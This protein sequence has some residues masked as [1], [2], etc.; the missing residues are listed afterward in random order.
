MEQEKTNILYG[1]APYLI[2]SL[3]KLAQCKYYIIVYNKLWNKV[4]QKTQIDVNIRFQNKGDSVVSTKFF[5]SFLGCAISHN[6][7]EAFK[8]VF[9]PLNMKSILQISMDGSN[10]N[11]KFK[12]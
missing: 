9:T 11:H 5:T 3:T 2:D 10:V 6:I 7:T 12:F 8:E 1:I 4:S